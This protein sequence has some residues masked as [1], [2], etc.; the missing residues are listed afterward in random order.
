MAVSHERA[1]TKYFSQGE[2]LLVVGFGLLGRKRS[3][4]RRDLAE[5]PQ[6]ISFMS[7]FLVGL[8]EIEGALRLDDCFV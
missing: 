7:P 1:H 8:R 4:K 2:G 5:E 6:G 3:A